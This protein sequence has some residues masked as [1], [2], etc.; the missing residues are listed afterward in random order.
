MHYEYLINGSTAQEVTGMD[1][2]QAQGE[3]GPDFQSTLPQLCTL[4]QASIFPSI[5]WNRNSTHALA[6]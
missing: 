2:F 4:G 1:G 5:D 3:L 6:G